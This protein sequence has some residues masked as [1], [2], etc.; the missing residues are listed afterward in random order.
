M[1]T[2]R[3]FGLIGL[4]V[5]GML[6]AQT[7]P[8]PEA[9]WA[10]DTGSGTIAADSS[11][12]GNHGTI[13]NAAWTFDGSTGAALDFNG[14][15]SRVVVD[16]AT[17]GIA[18]WSQLTISAWV[19]N[20]VGSGAG[21][22]DIVTWWDYP[23]SRSFVL[24]QHYT[25]HYFFEIANKGWVSGG[26][27]HPGWTHVGATYDGSTLRLYVDGIEVASQGGLSGS[28]PVSTADVLIGGQWDGSNDFDGRIDEVRLYSTALSASQI[29][30]LATPPV[31]GGITVLDQTV[32]VD[33]GQSVDVFLVAYGGDPATT[34]FQLVSPPVHG[35]ATLQASVSGSPPFVTYTP[36]P[37]HV[38]G[39][40]FTFRATDASG[41]SNLGVGDVFVA[42]PDGARGRPQIIGNQV[43]ADNG[44]PLRGEALPY[45]Q[46][47]L[48]KMYDV[49]W[50]TEMRDDF[51]LNTIRLIMYRPP[52]LWSGGPGYACTCLDLDDTVSGSLTTLDVMDDMVQMARD[53]GMYVII[54]YHPVGGHDDA[55]ATAWWS[56]VAPRYA[57]ETHVIYEF[58]NE[59]VQW[60]AGAYDA[61]DVAF[62]QN[63]YALLRSLAPQTHIILWTFANATGTMKEKVD[64]GTAIDYSNASVGFHAY[65]DSVS[66]MQELVSFYPTIQTEI[67]STVTSL[68]PHEAILFRTG[69]HEDNGVSWIWLNGAHYAGATGG[70]AEGY[71][72]SEVTWGA[73]PGAT[74]P[75]SDGSPPSVPGTPSVTTV[76]STSVTLT[77]GGSTDPESGLAN[78]R[79]YRDGQLV[80]IPESPSFID[81][82]LAPGTTYTYQVS[83]LNHAGL[84]SAPS[85]STTAT[86]SGSVGGDDPFRRG[87]ANGNGQI[88]LA[89][90]VAILSHLFGGIPSPSCSDANDVNADAVLDI[91][92]PLYLLAYLHTGGAAPPFPFISC[93]LDGSGL[94]CADYT[95]C[96]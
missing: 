82:G 80:A 48:S 66:G 49:G 72:P 23:S 71:L 74:A 70:P 25:N 5:S 76:T 4:L 7:F 39:D 91:A 35:T 46:W 63:G 47:N 56:V 62:E 67:G 37:G 36:D 77:W 13:V 45:G 60:W 15:D 40:L 34:S 87:D 73:D 55:D 1:R 93:D 10:F 96:P 64:E 75:S 94:D 95:A 44:V 69:Y 20:D 57:D 54:D 65:G 31:G 58:C 3:W 59:P 78:Y 6:G 18:S 92:D 84:E 61:D 79:V 16:R 30:Q 22:D 50:W 33:Q 17:L 51:H 41:V 2:T 9:H 85:G 81:G 19:S 21:T 27:I 12:G 89:D 83:A 52:Q 68:P 86:S 24:T 14:V 88:E 38:G 26:T 11:G 53:L 8:T 28:L 29:Q 43:R 90:A 32:V 42:G